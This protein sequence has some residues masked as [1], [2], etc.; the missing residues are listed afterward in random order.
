MY[1]FCDM[2]ETF[3]VNLSKHKHGFSGHW[4]MKGNKTRF[5]SLN[6]PYHRFKLYC[7]WSDILGRS[8]VVRGFI[9]LLT[10]ASLSCVVE[11]WL[12]LSAAELVPLAEADPDLAMVPEPP[13]PPP[14]PPASPL[15]VDMCSM[16]ISQTDMG[17]NV[18]KQIKWRLM[19]SACRWHVYSRNHCCYDLENFVRLVMGMVG[20]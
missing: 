8:S 2:F 3:S 4:G 19:M 10:R 7:K 6:D 5:P 12:M 13:P 14:P 18:F 1:V 20:N 11:E 15:P 17:R 16:P 9:P